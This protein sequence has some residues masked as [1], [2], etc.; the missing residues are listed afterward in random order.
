MKRVAVLGVLAGLVL[1]PGCGGGEQPATEEKRPTAEKYPTRLVGPYQTLAQTVEGKAGKEIQV[2]GVGTG[3]TY[4]ALY[5]YDQDGNCVAHDDMA[6][7]ATNDDTVA[8][9]IPHRDQAF[10]VE[11]VNLGPVENPIKYKER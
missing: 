5:V 4:T 1:L 3:V 6:V 9:W 11:L 2:I 7:R 10:A 8:A